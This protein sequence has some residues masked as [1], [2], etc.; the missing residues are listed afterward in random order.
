MRYELYYWPMI[1]GRGEYVRLA[2]EEAAADYAD[3]AREPGGMAAM[4]RLLDGDSVPRPSF[5]PPFL[6]A[7]RLLIGQTANILFYLGEQH[8]LAPASLGGR[9]WVHQL[10]LTIADLVAEIHDTHHPVATSLYY[11]DQKKP[12]KQRSQDFIANRLPKFFTYFETILK[13]N[14]NEN[15]YLAGA[16]LSYADLSL[17]QIVAG[18][19]YAFPRAMSQAV[20]NYPRVKALADRVAS[21]PRIAA[22]LA[23]DRRVPFNEDGIFRHYDE[24]D[25]AP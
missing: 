13:A 12:A 18:L 20:P 17:F 22:Y 4:Q 16:K 14:T 9:L 5:A 6:K 7:G 11:K 8:G 1:Q 3:I 15:H 24:L 19:N 10:Q 2:L 21:R 25:A 23:S